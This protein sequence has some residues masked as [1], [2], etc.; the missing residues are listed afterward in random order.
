MS[1][2]PNARRYRGR[3]WMWPCWRLKLWA[4]MAF[5]ETNRLRSNPLFLTIMCYLYANRAV[6]QIAADTEIQRTTRR[7]S[8]RDLICSCIDALLRDLEKHRVRDLERIASDIDQRLLYYREKRAFLE[9]FAA[10]LFYDERFAG[11]QVFTRED[12]YEVALELAQQENWPEAL[13]HALRE[14]KRTSVV[15]LL[16]SRGLFV[17]AENSAKRQA[18]DFPHQRFREVLVVEYLDNPER[19]DWALENVSNR[20]SSELLKV[21]FALSNSY[22]AVLLEKVLERVDE[23]D[24]GYYARLAAAFLEGRPD[25]YDPR[26]LLARWVRSLAAGSRPLDVP[27]E[28]ARHCTMTSE[29]SAWFPAEVLSRAINDDWGE[30]VG[31]VRS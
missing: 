3:R 25:F 8:L 5:D 2:W 6:G 1:P 29:L 20:R 27:E 26:P 4:D 7:S 21:F 30:L 17:V 24:D 12:L 9:N 23:E 31:L 22:Q 13:I 10:R 16:I 19:I 18:F 11:H 28:L 14:R 15:A